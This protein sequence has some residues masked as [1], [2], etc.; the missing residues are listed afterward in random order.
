MSDMKPYWVMFER[1]ATPTFLKMGVGV[2]ARSESDAR[3]IVAAAFSEARITTIE[4]VEGVGSLDQDHV[5]P[6]MGNMLR[7]GV[8][9]PK[10]FEHIAADGR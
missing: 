6:N 9:F 3:A 5:V 4:A 2:T 10:G 8:W 7:R 1:L